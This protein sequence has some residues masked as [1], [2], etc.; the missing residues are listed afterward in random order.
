MVENLETARV[1]I[2]YK[3]SVNLYQCE[4]IPYVRE[5]IEYKPFLFLLEGANSTSYGYP[6]LCVSVKHRLL[7]RYLNL[8]SKLIDR[9]ELASKFAIFYF[10]ST[11]RRDPF[12]YL[13]SC[14]NCPTFIPTNTKRA[15]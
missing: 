8:G 4:T 5:S 10:K 14:P 2:D 15:S 3:H 11:I 7:A 6:W 13:L 1:V 12:I 9:C